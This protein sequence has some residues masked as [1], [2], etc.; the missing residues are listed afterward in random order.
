[1]FKKMYLM[2]VA[3]KNLATH[4]LRRFQK[5]KRT[6]AQPTDPQSEYR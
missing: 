5:M 4:M 6:Y 2:S 3:W 1:M